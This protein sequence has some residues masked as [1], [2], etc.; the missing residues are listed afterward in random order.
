M[1]FPFSHI[2]DVVITE[3]GHVFSITASKQVQE[4]F[5]NK[6]LKVKSK[7]PQLSCFMFSRS[8]TKRLKTVKGLPNLFCAALFFC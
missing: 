1:I 4:W 8:T 6:G 3:N 2:C 7:K 5:M